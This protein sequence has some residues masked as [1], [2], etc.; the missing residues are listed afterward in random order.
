MP[1]KIRTYA[2][3]KGRSMSATF[4]GCNEN[5]NAYRALRAT[6]LRVR[7]GFGARSG[8]PFLGGATV[9]ARAIASSNGRG[10]F[11]AGSRVGLVMV[12]V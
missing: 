10:T 9:N 11:N 6:F 3:D 5:G 1:Y 4:V 8:Q 2:L 7:F 12:G